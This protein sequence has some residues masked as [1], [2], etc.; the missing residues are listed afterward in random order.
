MQPA[1]VEGVDDDAG[2][3]GLIDHT[4]EGVPHA[5]IGQ[6]RRIVPL[7]HQRLKS[8]G[9]EDDGL[10]TRQVARATDHE[11]EG[12]ERAGRRHRVPELIHELEITRVRHP[13]PRIDGRRL[14]ERFVRLDSVS[15][16]RV[17]A[18]T[19]DG[20]MQ[21]APIGGERLERA[22]RPAGSDERN[23]I[24][25]LQL[26]VDK[27]VERSSRVLQ[28]FNG[29]SQVVNHHSQCALDVCALWR[30]R[31]NGRGFSNGARKCAARQ[32]RRGNE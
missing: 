23:E 24:G 4:V 30:R 2:A 3:S 5:R 7:P 22:G 1:A 16:S 14:H 15:R 25:R 10:S 21:H 19:F 32:F 18:Q 27:R 13:R 26:T 28:A 12:A 9:D 11:V 20:G 6:F 31:R 8:L 29:Q 17:P